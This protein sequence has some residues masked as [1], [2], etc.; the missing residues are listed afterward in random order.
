MIKTYN[1]LKQKTENNLKNYSN[2]ELALI[3]QETNNSSIVAEVFCR[4]FNYWL[5]LSCQLKCVPYDERISIILE[6][7]HTGMETYKID[8]GANLLTYIRSCVYNVSGG[9]TTKNKYK[10]RFVEGINI[11]IDEE[12]EEGTKLLDIIPGDNSDLDTAILKLTIDTHKGL[13]KREKEL[14]NL[15]I[16][17]PNIETYEIGNLLHITTQRVWELK[18]DLQKKL[19]ISLY[20]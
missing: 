12:T 14:C 20:F 2:E 10:N 11:S 4:N 19:E 15:I 6:K 16:D 3:Y 7:I 5:K 17:S 13:N 8:Q 9:Y 1:I 18:K